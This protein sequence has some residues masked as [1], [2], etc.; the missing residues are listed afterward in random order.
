MNE[1]SPLKRLVL[2]GGLSQA[3]GVAQRLADLTQLPVV[4]SDNADATLQ[5]V[6][7]LVAQSLNRHEQWA[8]VRATDVLLPQVNPALEG[9]F[10][11]W[12]TQIQAWLARAT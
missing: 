7:F 6:G 1:L 12:Q 10:I 3:D 5:G 2:S 9:R 8:N 11:V 4:R